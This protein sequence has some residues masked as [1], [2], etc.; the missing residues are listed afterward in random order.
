[1]KKILSGIMAGVMAVSLCGCIGGYE[2]DSESSQKQEQ[3]QRFMLQP[4][5]LI[6]LRLPKIRMARLPRSMRFRD[7]TLPSVPWDASFS[8]SAGMDSTA[9]HVLP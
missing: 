7:I 5:F 3:V 1:M 9:L 6:A 8:G 4:I 2:R